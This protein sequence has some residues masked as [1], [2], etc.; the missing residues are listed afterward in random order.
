MNTITRT[1]ANEKLADGFMLGIEAYGATN[2]LTLRNG[3]SFIVTYED[4]TKQS[5]WKK[6]QEYFKKVD[7]LDNTCY[8]VLQGI[9][10]TFGI[11]FTEKKLNTVERALTAL[12]IMKSKIEVVD[13][14]PTEDRVREIIKDAIRNV[15]K[16]K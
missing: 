3:E 10:N 13:K 8:E 1:F 5:K 2:I 6:T 15:D 7:E 14:L 11:E 9:E 4:P 12:S 16:W